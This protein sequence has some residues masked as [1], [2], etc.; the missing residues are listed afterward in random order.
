MATKNGTPP[1]SLF[2]KALRLLLALML[3]SWA[4][5]LNESRA[6]MAE[7][8]GVSRIAVVVS[9]NIRPYLEAVDGFHLAF[10]TNAK[11]STEVVKLWKFQAS[12]M[13]S[14]AETLLKRP[15]AAYLAVGPE[16]LQF[17]ADYFD[18]KKVL[19]LYA[20][21]LN[22]SGA[23]G[24]D[25]HLCGIPLNIPVQEQLKM[26]AAGIPGARRI[27]LLYDPSHNEEFFQD[28]VRSASLYGMTILPLKVNG[29]KE[30]PSVLK[31]FLM[32]M[33][34][35]WLIPDRTVI[36]ESIVRYVIK[37]AFMK[38]VPAIGYNRFFYESGALVAFIFNYQELGEQAARKVLAALS[39]Q[40]C[41]DS[42]PLF[43]VWMNKRVAEK[44]QEKTIE[45]ISPPFVFGP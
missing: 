34:A 36:S 17:L 5:A 22:P 29:R 40:A 12:E 41:M 23:S 16:A 32:E 42:V 37:E 39:G 1:L 11:A 44:L 24:S 38:K 33:D 18:S 30:I 25:D 14:L 45:T 4:M 19:K 21:V 10:S 20:I 13:P 15:F 26:I 27:G 6:A 9:Q 3:I 31:K 43:Q 7:E 35:L 8:A 28:A 2:P